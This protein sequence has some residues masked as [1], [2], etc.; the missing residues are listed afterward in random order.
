MTEG[1][2][3]PLVSLNLPQDIVQML[4]E[5]LTVNEIQEMTKFRGFAD[6]LWKMGLSYAEKEAD[7]LKAEQGNLKGR[8]NYERNKEEILQKRK[9][10][11][12]ITKMQLFAL[13]RD[14]Q[15]CVPSLDGLHERIVDIEKR[16]N[17][18]V[19]AILMNGTK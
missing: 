7:I 13:L 1:A 3:N 6:E 11:W 14:A 15:T 19:M 9:Q 8:R 10:N 16:F 2:E 17:A 5:V 4:G 18:K 12:E